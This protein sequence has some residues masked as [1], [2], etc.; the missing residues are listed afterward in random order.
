M[1]RFFAVIFSLC[2]FGAFGQVPCGL[3]YTNSVM[4]ASSLSMVSQCNGEQPIILVPQSRL[5]GQVVST[6][7]ILTYAM[8]LENNNMQLNDLQ[9]GITVYVTNATSLDDN[10]F[11]KVYI[12]RGN[13]PDPN[14]PSS[15]NAFSI[16]CGYDHLLQSSDI[17]SVTSPLKTYYRNSQDGVY[18]IQVWGPTQGNKGAVAISFDIQ[19]DDGAMTLAKYV[20]VIAVPLFCFVFAMAIIALFIWKKTHGGWKTDKPEIV[21]KK[22]SK[23][24][25]RAE[26]LKR[27]ESNLSQASVAESVSLDT[28]VTLFREQTATINRLTEAVALYPD[29]VS[30]KSEDAKKM[31]KEEKKANKEDETDEDRGALRHKEG[32]VRK[33]SFVLRSDRNSSSSDSE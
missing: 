28:V 11:I 10:N 6:G 1:I 2:F 13:C 12:A 21:I 17:S 9:F 33:D 14:C 7:D 25:S 4:M 27:T 29:T 5:C 3:N 16:T 32:I 23:G 26:L 31:E 15:S 24:M 18:Y 19:I 30:K 20:P 22:D 8:I